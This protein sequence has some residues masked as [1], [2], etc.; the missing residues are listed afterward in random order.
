MEKSLKELSLVDHIT[1]SYNR[2]YLEEEES[3]KTKTIPVDKRE[4]I[5]NRNQTDGKYGIWGH[6]LGDLDLSSI[7]VHK[8]RNGIIK[9][10]LYIES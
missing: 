3:A 5:I 6:D 10:E 1:G 4:G 8:L 9:L 2:I 7:I